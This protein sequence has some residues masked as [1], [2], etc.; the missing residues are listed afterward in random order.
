MAHP[1]EVVQTAL[2]LKVELSCESCTVS[3]PSV[4]MVIVEKIDGSNFVFECP[5]CHHI[6][7]LSVAT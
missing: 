5:K 1:V 4:K 6:I 3:M 7:T 2:A